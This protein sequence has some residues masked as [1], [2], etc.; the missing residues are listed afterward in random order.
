MGAGGQ[1]GEPV[2]PGVYLVRGGLNLGP[3]NAGPLAWLLRRPRRWKCSSEIRR[4]YRSAG[5]WSALYSRLQRRGIDPHRYNDSGFARSRRPGP[6]GAPTYGHSISKAPGLDHTGASLRELQAGPGRWRSGGLR[7][8]I[9]AEVLRQG[10]LRDPRSH[11]VPVGV[12]PRG[13][14][15]R[16]TRWERRR[17]RPPGRRAGGSGHRG[18]NRGG[19]PGR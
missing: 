18:S 6:A 11:R 4:S 9:V 12:G 13:G 10:R 19:S 5:H 17:T 16:P 14:N 1:P 7:G 2:A 8:G 3:P 15:H